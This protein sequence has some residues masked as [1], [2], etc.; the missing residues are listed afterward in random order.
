M[1]STPKTIQIFLSSGELRPDRQALCSRILQKLHRI[2]GEELIN[3][4]QCEFM[5]FRLR[6]QQTIKRITVNRRKLSQM[7]HCPLVNWQRRDSM[8]C[9]LLRKIGG[10]QSR[11]GEFAVAV[12]NHRFLDRD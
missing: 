4:H 10:R 6:N 7:S 1:S 8:G 12:L 9:S 11:E 2:S 5:L 3:S